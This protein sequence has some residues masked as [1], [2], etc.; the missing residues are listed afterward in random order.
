MAADAA[1]RVTSFVLRVSSCFYLACV[2]NDWRA[3]RWKLSWFPS[4][5][6]TR[7]MRGEGEYD[8]IILAAVEADLLSTTRHRQNS[9]RFGLLDFILDGYF[10][11]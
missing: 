7:I 11:V 10:R 8:V 6:L 5:V 3:A 1:W 9:G 4:V 2:E